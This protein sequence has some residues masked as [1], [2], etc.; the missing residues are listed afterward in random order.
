MIWYCWRLTFR[1]FVQTH[2]SDLLLLKAKVCSRACL[3]GHTWC[4]RYVHL[5]WKQPLHFVQVLLRQ[6]LGMWKLLSCC[7]HLI[8][9][10]FYWKWLCRIHELP[11]CEFRGDL[12]KIYGF[13]LP[14]KP[15]CMKLVSTAYSNIP[16][17]GMNPAFECVECWYRIQCCQIKLNIVL[18]LAKSLTLW[19]ILA[20]SMRLWS[21]HEYSQFHDIEIECDAS[22]ATEPCLVSRVKNKLMWNA[23]ILVD[24]LLSKLF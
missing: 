7:K 5:P 23:S 4:A 3:H 20:N 12:L 14:S 15:S 24:G 10:F 11:Y 1:E 22:G 21:W 19:Y 13:V 9:E 6:I 16:T 8:F 2:Y 17:G 18:S